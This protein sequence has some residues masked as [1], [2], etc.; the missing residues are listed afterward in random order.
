MVQ[1]TREDDDHRQVTK[2]DIRCISATI[3]GTHLVSKTDIFTFQH[4][5]QM[6]DAL[7]SVQY[8]VIL[9]LEVNMTLNIRK[10]IFQV[11]LTVAYEEFQ[12]LKTS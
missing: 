2:S 7:W 8:I 5:M 3:Y 9:G 4:D 11:V 12:V 1:G 10:F 6:V